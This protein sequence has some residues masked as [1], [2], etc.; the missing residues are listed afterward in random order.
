[1]SAGDPDATRVIGRA[2]PAT[3]MPATL[4]PLDPDPLDRTIVDGRGMRP[5]QLGDAITR[6]LEQLRQTLLNLVPPRVEQLGERVAMLR[7]CRE[8]APAHFMNRDA[9]F[10]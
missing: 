10:S 1:M 7:P 2:K 5:V 3:R 9:T 8:A 6:R 4:A